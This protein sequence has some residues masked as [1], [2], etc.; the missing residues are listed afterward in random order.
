[1]AKH[2]I[3]AID[4]DGTICRHGWPDIG[5]PLP[6]AFEVMKRLQKMGH[7]LV[8]NTCREDDRSGKYLTEAVEFCANNGIHF[9]AVNTTH[10]D[11][12]FRSDGGRKVFAHFYIDD[13]NLGGFP[14]WLEVER[15]LTEQE[16]DPFL[17]KLWEVEKEATN[18]N[19]PEKEDAT[20]DNA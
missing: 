7:H 4:F 6:Y 18:V 3:L 10:P 11:D 13:R 5:E 20:Q 1:M 15:M 8:L 2:K 14:G 17:S 12:D 19:Y 9:R 16:T